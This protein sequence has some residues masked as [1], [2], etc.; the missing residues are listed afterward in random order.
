MRRKGYSMALR[1]G[2]YDRLI[3]DDEVRMGKA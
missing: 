2:L 3:Y 1:T